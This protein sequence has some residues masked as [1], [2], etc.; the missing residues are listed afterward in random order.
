[1]P[2]SLKASVSVLLLVSWRQGSTRLVH[3][4]SLVLSI[5]PV[6]VMCKALCWGHRTTDSLDRTLQREQELSRELECKASYA[7]RDRERLGKV[8]GERAEDQ[9]WA[10]FAGGRDCSRE[11]GKC[12]GCDGTRRIPE[13]AKRRGPSQY[14][15]IHNPLS[16]VRP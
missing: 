2:S 16:W 15:R 14:H 1:M 9:E 3:F 13:T 8:E 10:A 6:P 5:Y 7:S 12:L 11:G 4:L